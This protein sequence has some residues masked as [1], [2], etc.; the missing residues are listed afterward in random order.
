MAARTF[1][2]AGVNNLWSNA[3]NWDGGLTIPQEDDSVTIPAGQTCEYDY[4][5]AYTTG[6]AGMT[7]TGTFS[8]TRTAGTYRLFMKEATS[9]AGAGT[10]DCGTSV[11]PIPLA[12]KHTITGGVGFKFDGTAGLSVSVYDAEPTIKYV[13][14][15]NNEAAGATVIEVDTDV[16]GDIWADGDLVRIVPVKYAVYGYD[17]PQERTIATGGIAAGS[18]TITA[19]ITGTTFDAGSLVVLVSRNV[20][21][22]GTASSV[23][24]FDAF[25]TAKIVIGGGAWYGNTEA[26]SMRCSGLVATGGIWLQAAFSMFSSNMNI[27]NFIFCGANGIW[28]ANNTRV[29]DTLF[30]G[31]STVFSSCYGSYVDNCEFYCVTSINIIHG[32]ISNC[33]GEGM[34]DFLNGSYGV[35]VESCTTS[36]TYEVIYRSQGTIFNSSFTAGTILSYFQGRLVN[37]LLA[38]TE[39]IYYTAASALNYTESID[40]DQVSG[41]YKAWT[42]GGVTTKQT[43]TKPTGESYSMQT[44]LESATVEGYV[45]KEI[46]VSAGASVDMNFYLRKDASMTYLPRVVVFN[47]SSTDPLAGGAAIETFTMTNS[48]DTWETDNYVYTNTTSEDV[49]LVIRC[50]GKNATGNM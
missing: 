38:G 43:T 3:A 23:S 45:Q 35:V 47:K 41:A 25:Q 50:Q 14:T 2:S 48:V 9:I 6:I 10:F 19:G 16:T 22:V 42:V 37:T 18:I 40:H 33:L 32:S 8:L 20:K 30:A 24:L 27:S 26:Y 29:T 46:L 13:K 5:S 34:A 28:S 11:S 21:I 1:T 31:V 7:V 17:K 12:A 44:V 36:K 39:N 49:T 4:N 15:L